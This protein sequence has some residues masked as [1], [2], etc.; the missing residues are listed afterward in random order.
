MVARNYEEYVRDGKRGR[1]ANGDGHITERRRNLWGSKVQ[2]D[3]Y[4]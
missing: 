4:G 3:D 2:E 1:R